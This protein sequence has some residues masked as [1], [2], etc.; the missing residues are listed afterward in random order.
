M[1][2]SFSFGRPSRLK[3][4]PGILPAGV[5]VLAVVDGQGQEVES[6]ARLALRA[7]GGQDHGV[8]EAHE[9]G[10]VGLL[11][12]PPRLD[13]QGVAAKGH[14]HSIHFSLALRS[15][16][17]PALAARRE[18]EERARATE[19]PRSDADGAASALWS[20]GQGIYLRMPSFPIRPR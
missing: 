7:G 5:G 20:G 1:R 11:G 16:P 18:Q 2:I 14:F 15:P 4:P 13:R 3:K 19:R 8:A 17:A 10:A 6:H 9:D 12:H